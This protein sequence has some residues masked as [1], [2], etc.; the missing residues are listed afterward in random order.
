M[1]SSG[2]WGGRRVSRDCRGTLEVLEAEARP[3]CRFCSS[4]LGVLRHTVC[5]SAHISV[6]IPSRT[7]AGDLAFTMPI[8]LGDSEFTAHIVCDDKE[9]EAYDV[10]QEDDV[11]VSCWIA[12]EEGKVSTA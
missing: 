12:S 10:V 9:L 5:A 6:H 1:S 3:W 2:C 8:R 4:P 11:T 7:T